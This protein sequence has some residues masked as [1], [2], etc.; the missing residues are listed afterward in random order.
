LDADF[1]GGSIGACLVLPVEAVTL[2]DAVFAAGLDVEDVAVML[3]VA[4]EAVLDAGLFL[5]DDL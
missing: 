1:S 2:A 5:W 3:V 4:V